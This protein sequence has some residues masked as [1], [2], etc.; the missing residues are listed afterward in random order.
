MS[1]WIHCLQPANL[2][3]IGRVTTMISSGHLVA[4]MR[5]IKKGNQHLLFTV[6]NI[7]EEQFNV[8]IIIFIM[9]IYSLHY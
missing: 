7:Q 1:H 6:Y 4:E 3:V 8:N 5:P 2:E 9:P